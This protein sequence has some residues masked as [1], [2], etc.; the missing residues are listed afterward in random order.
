MPRVDCPNIADTGYSPIPEGR[1]KACIEKVD[2]KQTTK[3][4]EMWSVEWRVIE[5]QY[6]GRKIW[7]NITFSEKGYSRVKLLLKRLGFDITVPIDCEPDMIRGK[8][9]WISVYIDPYK[10]K[11]TNKIPFDGFLSIDEPDKVD[12]DLP[13]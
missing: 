12:D 10:G 11:D 13:Y 1:Y 9:A 7:D 5:G 3:G 2:V 4:D 6:V 8:Q